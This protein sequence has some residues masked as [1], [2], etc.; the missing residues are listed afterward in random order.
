MLYWDLAPV[1]V[2][3]GLANTQ[4]YTAFTITVGVVGDLCTSL[5]PLMQ[6]VADPVMRHL[7][8]AFGHN[9][10]HSSAH[11]AALSCFG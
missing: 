2:E 11:P 3:R 6:P 1:Q 9:G 10:T 7:C 5:G 4:D 8:A